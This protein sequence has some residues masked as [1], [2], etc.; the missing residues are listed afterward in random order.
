MTI[1]EKG[2]KEKKKVLLG[3]TKPACYRV[4]ACQVTSRWLVRRGQSFHAKGVGVKALKL[5]V[6][7]AQR[8]RKTASVYKEW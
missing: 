8:L 7:V 6:G 2:K 4:E 3:G 5:E 1:V